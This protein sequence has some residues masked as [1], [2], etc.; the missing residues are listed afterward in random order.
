VIHPHTNPLNYILSKRV[1]LILLHGT[2]WHS[3]SPGEQA[4]EL[5]SLLEHEDEGDSDEDGDEDRDEEQ[6]SGKASDVVATAAASSSVAT[7]TA[8]AAAPPRRVVVKPGT[9]PTRVVTTS[10]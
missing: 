7:A 2:A 6:G 9:A 5:Q 10:V 8:V 4:V 3:I 1:F